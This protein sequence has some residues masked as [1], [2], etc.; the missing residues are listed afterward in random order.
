MI[1]K[2]HK[3]ENMSESGSSLL[4]MISNPL[5]VLDL[6]VREAVQNSLDAY[7][8]DAKFVDVSFNVG[9]FEAKQ[10]NKHLKKATETLDEMFPSDK[11]YDYVAIRDCNTTGLTGP[12][13]ISRITDHKNHGNLCKLVYEISKPQQNEG[14]GGSWGH[15]KTIYFQVGIGL[16][17]YYSRIFE[18][19]RYK[20]RLAACLVED[21][22]KA[23]TIL[24]YDGVLKSGIAWW[25][26]ESGK[27]NIPIEDENEIAKILKIF[28]LEPYKDSETG[29]TII[30]PYIN[31]EKLLTETY[32]KN[33]DK[34]KRPS[35]T[36]SVSEYLN[37]AVQ[38]WYA[39][40]L[41]NTKYKYGPYLK[42]F[43]NTKQIVPS[44]MLPLF[45]MIREF[46]MLG[47]ENRLAED[48]FVESQGITPV[49]K[50]CL[51]NGIFADSQHRKAGTFIF[52]KVSKYEMLMSPP[53]NNSSP[54]QQ[55]NNL[56]REYDKNDPII[57]YTRKP[58]MIVT[59]KCDSFGIT[60]DPNNFIVGIFVPN[61]NNKL[62]SDN[63]VNGKTIT[64]EEYLR[65][66]E[67]DDH[68][69]WVDKPLD[70]TSPKIVA[71]IA[72]RFK[73]YLRDEFSETSSQ[74]KSYTS[75][76]LGWTLGKILLPPSGFG[77][78]PSKPHKPGQVGPGT[79]GK[80]KNTYIQLNETPY[81]EDGL[82]VWKYELCL[83][84]LSSE[85]I[86][87]ITTDSGRLNADA[88][89]DEKSGIG[90]RFPVEIVEFETESICC[91]GQ[92]NT[93][94]QCQH[95]ISVD[96]N[97]ISDPK[98]KFNMM[99]IKSDIYQIASKINFAVTQVSTAPI[100][101]KG[102]IKLKVSERDIKCEL[103]L[104]GK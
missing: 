25:G 98:Y 61:S 11:K 28:G 84:D 90:T 91:P 6:L 85:L 4:R 39:P 71:N 20:S 5:P 94:K 40:R 49:V 66:G 93:F 76:G 44:G 72:N 103:E 64:L 17:V 79:R 88:W 22:T 8:K 56:Y 36:K 81:F 87:N 18:D 82:L 12:V 102:C 3:Y 31:N 48:S 55:I 51:L 53:N 43:I 29:T 58:G 67:K 24:E 100:I 35:W 14:A 37:V 95:F 34:S 78:K 54:F 13:S 23:K 26:R 2:I 77:H 27:D 74:V 70:N 86:I 50:D 32:P 73:K 57:L 7:K 46:Y 65:R 60:S 83:K 47:D 99:L 41:A 92:S 38:R 68:N 15:G 19:G 16:V 89:E 1:I 10:F 63:K 80:G 52:S 101:L 69:L 59:Y 97:F 75:S 96:N 9:Q 104:K 45:R 30:I 62:D 33:E 42:A 21:E